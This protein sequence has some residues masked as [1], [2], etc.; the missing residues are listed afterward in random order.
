MVNIKKP[1][2]LNDL[3]AVMG[4]GGGVKKNGCSNLGWWTHFSFRR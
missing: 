4:G 1:N 3:S 2:G